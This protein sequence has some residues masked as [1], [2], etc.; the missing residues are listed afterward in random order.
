[1]VELWNAWR[2]VTRGARLP[3]PALDE[4]VRRRLQRVLVSAYRD[5]PYYREVMT[6]GGYDPTRD[7]RGPEDLAR[8][9][10][11][12]KETLKARGAAFIREGADLGACFSDTT[13][14]STGIPLRVY[15]DQRT[16]ALDI[17]KWLRVLVANGYSVRGKAMALVAPNRVA[18]GRSPLQRF[19]LLRRQAVDYVHTPMETI[20]DALL[21]YRPQVLYGNRSHL[22]LLALELRRRGIRVESL[23]GLIATAEIIHPYSRILYRERFG[24]E[25]AESYGS[26]EMGVMAY[27][28]R[29]HDGLHLCEDLTYF[30][31]LDASGRPV[32][33]GEPGRVV[34]TDLTN[35][36]MPFIR[37]DQGDLVVFEV[38]R[39]AAGEASRR[40]RQ[41]EGRDNDFAVLPDGRR[42][43]AQTLYKALSPFEAV[44]QFRIVQEAPDR[45]RLFVA[46]DPEY[47][48][49]HGDTM[50]DAVRRAV[51][52]PVVVSVEA[53]ACIE[54]DPA[55][56][57]RTFVSQVAT[58]VSTG[59][60]AG[61]WS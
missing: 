4:L 24:V 43:P 47:C 48:A 20:A 8:F 11:I 14:G 15:R 18:L 17:A 44:H 60:G 46:A 3:R 33:P 22:D 12:R 40:I 34:V 1:M 52:A 13:S 7:Y 57:T 38:H 49:R 59:G 32:G 26:V 42:L 58:P 9:P 37:Y 23:R 16:R 39:S 28:T 6:S 36:L 56:K 30:E 41:I 35:T 61:Q 45:F 5:V 31:F 51:P 10:V 29:A 54:P 25:V 2:D 21:A 55:G 50:I 19:G 27:E 53:V